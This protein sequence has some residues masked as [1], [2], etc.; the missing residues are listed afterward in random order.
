MAHDW[1]DMNERALAQANAG[2]DS[3]ENGYRIHLDVGQTFQG[4]YR[5]E[6][7]DAQFDR[8]IFLFWDRD[9]QTCYMREYAS[10]R[11]RI[12]QAT[13]SPGDVV[14]IAR[15]DDYTSA[16]GTGY[17]FGVMVVTSDD[18]L[19]VGEPVPAQATPTQTTIDDED[20]IPW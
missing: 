1:D 4:R 17:S 9:D 2:P 10:L 5:G 11:R 7:V 19:P 16:N 12:D 15:G 14:V 3:G 6:T 20:D 13:P 18:P 8:A